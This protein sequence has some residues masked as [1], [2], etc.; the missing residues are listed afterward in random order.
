MNLA[1]VEKLLDTMK[2]EIAIAHA[3]PLKAKEEMERIRK[4][5]APGHAPAAPAAATPAPPASGGA[6]A[7]PGGVPEGS[8][9]SPSRKQWRSPDGKMFD[10]SGKAVP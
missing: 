9:Y 10:A 4:S 5:G 6:P 1:H 8:A 3:A 7:R 2:K